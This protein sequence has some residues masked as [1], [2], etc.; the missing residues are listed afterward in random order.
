[1]RTLL[2]AAVVALFCVAF[3]R[4]PQTEQQTTATSTSSNA[5]GTTGSDAVGTA[6]GESAASQDTASLAKS[7][8]ERD[9]E[10]IK[11]L[12]SM[13]SY[14][15]T[16]KAFQIRSETSRDEVLDDGQNVEFDG[17]VDMLVERP[18]RLRAEVTSDK[19]QRMYFADGK[20]FSVWA[21]RLNYYATVPASGTL[22]ELG[23]RLADKYNVELP[24]W[25]LFYWGERKSTDQIVDATDLGGSQVDG[26]TCEHYAFRQEGVDWQ[27][28]I[29]QGSYPL[30]RKLVITTTTD[31]AR[32]RYTSIMTWNLAPSYDDTAFTFVP[33]PSAKRISLAERAATGQD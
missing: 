4:D 6:S 26:V 33:G 24:L 30:P 29:Q 31:S 15:R 28:W 14:L 21:R 18:N 8:V 25:D 22:A 3:G 12:E 16:L 1:M 9:P 10:A 20:S 13:G 11:A 23:D 2:T 19:N 5:E 7:A 17:V 27:V 32:P